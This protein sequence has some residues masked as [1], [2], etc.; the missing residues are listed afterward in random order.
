M[1]TY[2]HIKNDKVF[3][4]FIADS[5]EIAD[6]LVEA[7]DVAVEVTESTKDAY[8]GGDMIDGKFRPLIPGSSDR[9]T[10]NE[11]NFGWEYI[12]TEEELIRQ[13]P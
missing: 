9:Y 7:N 10:W 13:H 11:E 8:I 2:A 3:N 5:Q 4:V 6:D 1:K 12:P